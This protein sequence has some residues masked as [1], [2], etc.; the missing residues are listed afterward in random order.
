MLRISVDNLV[1]VTG[2]ELLCGSVESHA[3]GLTIDSRQSTAGCVFVALPGAQVDGHDFARE[4]LSG[5]ARVLVV[6]RGREELLPV[7]TSAM[8]RGAS[9]VRVADALGAVSDLAA[10]HRSRM[11]CAVVGITGSTGKTT[12]KD[13]LTAVLRTEMR[14][15]S[16]QGN[17]NNDLGVPL[18]LLEAGSDTDVLVVE[19]GMRG[20]GEI[21]RLSR[22]AKPTMGLVT[23]VGTSHIE[24]LGSV[25]AI[26]QAKGELVEAILSDG[27]VFL[28]GDDVN[29]DRLA[30][31]AVAPVTRYGLSDLCEVRAERVAIDEN[32]L[33][34][35]DLV[36]P[37]GEVPVTLSVPGRHNIYNALAAASVALRLAV[38]LEHVAEGLARAEVTAMRM[39]MFTTASSVTV[40]NDAYNAN[41]VS[42][43]AAIETLAALRVDGRRIAV[44]GDM[45]ELGQLADLAHFEIGE[46]VARCGIDVLVTVGRRSRRIAEGARAEGMAAT[47]VR[48]CAQVGEA[49]GVLDDLVESGDTV[50]VKASR[51]MGLEAVVDGLVSPHDR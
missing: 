13:M 32:S 3:V 42:M 24:R 34:S 11:L 4:A 44:L 26:A 51:F 2:G 35:F 12:T 17:R 47:D 20:P 48:P 45:G 31:M 50:L 21:A 8:G 10:W 40:I 46:L 23:N 16:T 5:G 41:P 29:T 27:A 25:D 38:S 15:V 19:M 39:E 49:H 43:R 14:V 33:A 6:T 7:L 37:Q 36:T 18:T 28:N 30:A 1:T 9:V 22:L